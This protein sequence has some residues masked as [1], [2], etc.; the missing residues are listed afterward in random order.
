[1][2]ENITYQGDGNSQLN[3]PLPDSQPLRISNASDYNTLVMGD[4]EV[5][6]LPPHSD[7]ERLQRPTLTPGMMP[8]F[9]SPEAVAFSPSTTMTSIF[10]HTTTP[11]STTKNSTAATGIVP[12][13]L[14][15]TARRGNMKL[16]NSPPDT[17][18]TADSTF[19]TGSTEVISPVEQRN[20]MDSTAM[21]IPLDR[22]GSDSMPADFE[23]LYSPNS[24]Q[25]KSP[26]PPTVNHPLQKI[27]ETGASFPEPT[28]PY[29]FPS[30]SYESIPGKDPHGNPTGLQYEKPIP[31]P[32]RS[33][34]LCTTT[35]PVCSPPISP[36]H[37]D[38]SSTKQN[39]STMHVLPSDKRRQ[40]GCK[41]TNGPTQHESFDISGPI[42]HSLEQPTYASIQPNGS[43]TEL[44][45]ISAPPVYPVFE[46]ADFTLDSDFSA[47]DTPG[48]PVCSADFA[49]TPGEHLD[50]N[51]VLKSKLR[52][53]RVSNE[54]SS[55]FTGDSDYPQG[56]NTADYTGGSSSTAYPESDWTGGTST[57]GRDMSA[58]GR[59]TIT[60][61]LLP[62]NGTLGTPLSHSSSS[63][64]SSSHTPTLI[65]NGNCSTIA[66]YPGITPGTSYT[67]PVS[68]SSA[69]A[70]V[71]GATSQTM[72]PP[73][74][75]YKQLDPATMEPHL[76]YTRLN[77]G[78]LTA[79]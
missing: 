22:K 63:T 14:P 34:H 56:D 9:A 6:N 1:M 21:L 33:H 77:V 78:K 60:P 43:A 66:M 40:G 51:S 50:S 29:P 71:S 70:D 62:Y 67:V 11:H 26:S 4:Y 47:N 53:Q 61:S 46:T 42:Y 17:S 10:T 27:P 2:L 75:H 20:R 65:P 79:V 30:G 55:D 25:K 64:N 16:R 13:P 35:L 36:P 31:S 23:G 48:F 39:P 28:N 8:R 37:S 5:V 57:G 19:H 3:A 24:Q 54:F 45:E 44:K 7:Y 49:E 73:R 15:S 12:P 41:T 32:K 59:E 69:V 76:K 38:S 18:A 72:N 74:N 68:G 52:P 58:G